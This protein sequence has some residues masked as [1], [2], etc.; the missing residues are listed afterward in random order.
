MFMRSFSHTASL[1]SHQ[2]IFPRHFLQKN[3]MLASK[4]VKMIK[5]NLSTSV[6]FVTYFGTCNLFFFNRKSS[7]LC[8]GSLF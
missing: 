1:L 8:S 2:H 3:P 4:G 7:S 5:Y 6:I